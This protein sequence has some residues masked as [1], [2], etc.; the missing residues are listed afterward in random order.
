[1]DTN[2]P[3][4][5]WI[6]FVCAESVKEALNWSIVWVGQS[7]AFNGLFWWAI[8]QDH[9]VALANAKSMEPRWLSTMSLPAMPLRSG[10]AASTRCP[11]PPDASRFFA[12]PAPAGTRR[13]R[14]LH[15]RVVLPHQV[16]G[17]LE[18][19]LRHSGSTEPHS[20]EALRR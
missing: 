17:N 2:A 16:R 1:M 3:T 14:R 19:R 20:N 11:Q 18:C 10:S 6:F 4:W 7:F 9:G 13:G 5:L 12:C 8:Y 15:G